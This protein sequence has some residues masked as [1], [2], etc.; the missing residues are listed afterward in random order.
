M[1]QIFRQRFAS[2]VGDT[3]TGPVWVLI[4]LV[5]IACGASSSIAYSFGVP[6]SKRWGVVSFCAMIG[7]ASLLISA[8]IGFLFGVPHY[9]GEKPANNLDNEGRS[10]QSSYI[11]STNLEQVSDWLTKILLG[12]GLTQFSSIGKALGHLFNA[13]RPGLGNTESSAA[14]AGGLLSYFAAVGFIGGYLFTVRYLR[15]VLSNDPVRTVRPRADASIGKA[16]RH[17]SAGEPLRVG[18]TE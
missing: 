3:T 15:G 13:L 7:L 16:G 11:N 5:A 17:A 9:A 8:L 18:D 1:T 14:F 2:R 10:Q 12:V 6:A 4:P